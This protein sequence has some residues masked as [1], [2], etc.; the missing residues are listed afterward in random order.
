MSGYVRLE[1]PL[2]PGDET[3]P[4]SSYWS[5]NYRYSFAGSY[6]NSQRNYIQFDASTANS[7]YSA[8]TIRPESGYALMI[9]KA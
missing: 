1:R 4:F 5:G 8:N 6:A 7:I 2:L 3:A 9:I